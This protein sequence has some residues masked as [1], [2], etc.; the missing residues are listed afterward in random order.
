M[1]VTVSRHSAADLTDRLGIDQGKIRVIYNPVREWRHWARPGQLRE[2]LGLRGRI[3]S[4][5]GRPEPHKNLVTLVQAMRI[6]VGQIDDEEIKL[7]IAGSPDERYPEAQQ[8]AARLG[9]SERVVFTGY[10]DDARLGALYQTSDVFVFPSLYEGFGLPPLEAMRF[11][12]PVVAGLRTAPPEVL[13]T[14][15]LAVDTR[16]PQAIAAGILAVL[17]NRSLAARLRQA[18][19]CQA[20]H[21]SR[22]RAAE[23][24]R[25]LY[26]EL[27]CPAA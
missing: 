17:T 14:A 25:Q 3:I 22:R 18:G 27:L 4:C 13:G 21:Y 24:Y 19:P 16:D 7:V 9:L 1:V 26:Q 12:T 10:L 11:G 5:V 6:I 2:Q 20:A 8:Q 15:A 23:Q